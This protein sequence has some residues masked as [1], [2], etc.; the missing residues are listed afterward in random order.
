MTMT[1]CD[2]RPGYPGIDFGVLVEVIP[3]DTP[4]ETHLFLSSLRQRS[5]IQEPWDPRFTTSGPLSSLYA[6]SSLSSTNVLPMIQL[7]LFPENH[8]SKS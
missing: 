1:I 4:S 6:P 5:F 3:W 7:S 2:R 8:D